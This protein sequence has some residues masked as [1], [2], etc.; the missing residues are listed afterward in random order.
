MKKCEQKNG[1]FWD[2]FRDECVQIKD[3][4]KR[5]KKKG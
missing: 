5:T 1:G 4:K 3:L 2:R